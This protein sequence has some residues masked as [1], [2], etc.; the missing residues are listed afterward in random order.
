[1]VVTREIT[2]DTQGR[3]HLVDITLAM[4]DISAL[5]AAQATAYAAEAG[6]N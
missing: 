4:D 3:C 2:L 6:P 1:M 5:I